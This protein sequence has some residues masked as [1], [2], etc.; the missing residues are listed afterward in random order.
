MMEGPPVEEEQVGPPEEYTAMVPD[1]AAVHVGEP[2]ASVQQPPASAAAAPAEAPVAAAVLPVQESPCAPP[3]RPRDVEPTAHAPTPLLA[4]LLPPAPKL[5]RLLKKTSVPQQVCPQPLASSLDWG[6]EVFKVD[7]E[8]VS[9][10]FFRKLDGRQRY[11]WVYEKLRGFYVKQVHPR[12]LGKKGMADFQKLK[13]SERQK[14]ARRAFTDLESSERARIASAWMKASAPPRH[15]AHVIEEQ[16]IKQASACF[17]RVKTKGALLT[18][19]LPKDMVNTSKVVETQEP[20]ALKELVDHLRVSGILQEAWKDIQLHAQTCLRLAGA[21]DVAVCLEVCPDTWGAQKEVQLHFHAFL[22]SQGPDL[23]LRNLGP[24]SYQ[25]VKPHMSG[26]IGGMPMNTN[27]RGSWAGYFYCS[28]R[29]KIGTLFSQATRLPFKGF[30]VSPT[31]V[32]NLVQAQKLEADVARALLVQCASGSRHIRELDLHE[33][34]LEQAAVKKAQEESQRLLGSTLKPSKHYAEVVA[35][36]KQFET[37]LHRYKFLVLSGPS[38]VGK[39]AFAR[40]LCDPGFET[41]ELNC[42]SGAEPDLRAYRLSKHGLILFDEI[43][44]QQVVSQRK[45]FQSQSAGVQLGCSAT[46]MYSY[47]VYVWRKKLV[48]ASNNWDSSLSQ[49]SAPDQDWIRANS[50]VLRVTEPMWQE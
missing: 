9:A 7:E 2:T 28:I 50:I 16:I 1:A 17:G 10:P 33:G 14:E 49:L 26:S 5:R 19:M 42:A 25:D 32:L 48:L 38:R 3:K 6:K 40:S 22:K 24:F 23:R 11:N 36:I 29:D 44:A 8:F 35:F 15:V 34:H 30:L 12:T 47:E 20:T 21:S 46:N 39:T 27:G 13:G 37:P 18:W 43:I 31:W 45:V 4:G 41:L